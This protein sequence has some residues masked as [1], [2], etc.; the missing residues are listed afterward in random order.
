MSDPKNFRFPTNMKSTDPALWGTLS[1]A[2]TDEEIAEI[3]KRF[4]EDQ[5]NSSR[6]DP[7]RLESGAESFSPPPKRGY[8]W[9]LVLS[10]IVPVA[11]GGTA[12]IVLL[13]YLATRFAP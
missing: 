1:R 10:I 7:S 12:L 4:L 9:R 11:V 2:L 13:E 5:I 3:G 8:P 6:G